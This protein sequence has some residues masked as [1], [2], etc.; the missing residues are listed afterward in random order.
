MALRDVT[1]FIPSGHTTF[2]IGKSGSGKST[3]GQLLMRFY[4]PALGEIFLD[5]SPL[6]NLD[7]MWLRR[8][9]TLVEQHTSLFED[10]VFNNIALGKHDHHRITKNEVVHAVEFA[11]LKIM[12][13]DMPNGL[14]TLVG[15]RGTTM[16]G[17]QRQRMALARAY[18]R[19][20]PVLM[21]DESTSALDQVSRS[22]MIDAIREWRQGKTTIIITHDVSQILVSDYTIIFEH[23][24]LVQEGYRQNLERIKG[25][26]FQGFMTDD[27]QAQLSPFDVRRHTSAELKERALAAELPASPLDNRTFVDDPLEIHFRASEKTRSS[28][29]PTA[30]T[31][32]H[33]SAVIQGAGRFGKPNA[34]FMPLF[35]DSTNSLAISPTSS[36]SS[37]RSWSDGKEQRGQHNEGKGFT[38]HPVAPGVW[39][40]YLNKTGNLAARARLPT[41]NRKRQRLHS[42][43]SANATPTKRQQKRKR[44]PHLRSRPT[45]PEARQVDTVTSILRTI[46]PSLDWSSRVVLIIGFMSTATGAAGSPVFSYILAQL[47]ETYGTGAQGKHKALVYSLSIIGIAFVMAASAFFQHYCLEYA[48]QRW[49]NRIR[50]LA[51]E[52]ILN[53]PRD[54][55]TNDENSVS[56]ITESLDRHAEEMRNLLGRFSSIVL[57]AFIMIVVS[58]TWALITQWKITLVALA[59]GPYV[60][61]VTKAFSTVSGKWEARSNNS[62]EISSAIFFE[63]FTTIKTVRAL[64][65]EKH[66]SEKH[67]TATTNTLVIGLKRALWSGFFYG[68]ADVSGDFVMALL[69]YSG[70]V[71]IRDGASAAKIVQVFV[72]LIITIT[73]VS[74][75]LNF[76]PQMSA[77]RDMAS[78]ILRLSRLPNDSHENMGTTRIATIGD[79][80]F[81]N[82]TFSYP[83]RPDQ[84]ILNNVSMTI[85]A[86]KCTAIV[87]SSGS[88]K[89]TVAS[90]LLSLYTTN[91]ASPVLDSVPDLMVAGRNIKHIHTP[92]LRSLITIVSQ[93]PT[94]FSATI[95]ENI[96]YGLPAD[97]RYRDSASVRHAAAA[98]GIDDFVMSLP[99]GYATRVGE[100]GMGLSGGQAQRLAIARA[101]VRRPAVLILD[102]ATS[103]LDVENAGLIRQTVGSLV[104]GG[105]MASM[106]VIIITHSQEMMS[107]AEKI[108]VLD[109]GE[110][111]EQGGYDELLSRPGPFH[112]L[113]SGGEWAPSPAVRKQSVTVEGMTGT[114]DWGG[115]K[116]VRTKAG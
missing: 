48:G 44:L 95:A 112:H 107:I 90:L 106:A 45:D 22:L 11:L 89:S 16:S 81:T 19:D 69:F 7:T 39:E 25:G 82:L 93:S 29:L 8:Q 79:I 72:Q 103:A 34:G 49:I 47:F 6:D 83:S 56:R 87:G 33:T 94:L 28:F 24:K 71:F 37:R 63:T 35:L 40:T 15:S 98:A 17:G 110:V 31:N 58:I 80:V 74:T 76:I 116:K 1:L 3:L 38:Q 70:A 26:A 42:E 9:I 84:V 27:Q 99:L 43:A 57:T 66:F 51:L 96:A 91:N 97:S 113:V 2:I 73:N 13:S 54:F 14:D 10:T 50:E 36:T 88:G 85:P 104:R 52:R 65:L 23:G 114:V 92:T 59:V 41:S 115:S 60:W 77:A 111:V 67:V 4:P 75:L 32:K 78:R 61:F 100:G 62:S 12:V 18:L 5:D 108:I 53:Q 86:N 21:L 55:H 105:D 46:W 109:Q 68:L 64:V 30:F 101:L 20:T 102:E